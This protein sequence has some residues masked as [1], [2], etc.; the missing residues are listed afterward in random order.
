VEDRPV[1]ISLYL[2]V[3]GWLPCAAPAEVAPMP[4]PVVGTPTPI[5]PPRNVRPWKP[6]ADR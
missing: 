2:S 3:C 4:R 5:H 1:L 6:P